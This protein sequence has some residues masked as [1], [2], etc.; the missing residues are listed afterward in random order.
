MARGSPAGLRQTSLSLPAACGVLG[1][2]FAYTAQ[3]APAVDPQHI[4]VLTAEGVLVLS[5]QAFPLKRIAP[6]AGCIFVSSVV[7]SVAL[8]VMA[9]VVSCPAG[10]QLLLIN[11]TA[12]NTSTIVLS[13]TSSSVG[14]LATVGI[15]GLLVGSFDSTVFGWT[16]AAGIWTFAADTSVNSLAVSENASTSIV[17]VAT[18]DSLVALSLLSGLVLWQYPT[19]SPSSLFAANHKNLFVFLTGTGQ[20]VAVDDLEGYVVWTLPAATC[21]SFLAVAIDCTTVC[22]QGS[23]LVSFSTASGLLLWQAPLAANSTVADVLVGPTSVALL[24]AGPAGLQLSQ[25]SLAT[26]LVAWTT[27]LPGTG[28]QLAPASPGVLLA[29]AYNTASSYLYQ[30]SNANGVSPCPTF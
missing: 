24:Q 18:T 12:F 2:V 15:D 16:P 9:V 21:T 29:L 23:Q 3:F 17:A 13:T 11:N 26:G 25:L 20:V 27:T 1:R 4:S 30:F 22:V 14:L 6:E 5:S 8:G 28:G 7:S 10:T 19:P